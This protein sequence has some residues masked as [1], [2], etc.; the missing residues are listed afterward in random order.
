MFWFLYIV[1]ALGFSYLVSMPAKKYH[2][3]IFCSSLVVLLT[4]AQIEVGSAGYAPALFSFLF[5]I[6]LE[7]DYS[8]RALRPLVL[9]IPFS[10]FI[11]LLFF[12]FKKRIF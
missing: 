7:Q 1:A 10:F 8:L 3:I 4:P 6:F 5:N 11:L 9:S 2:M 12:S